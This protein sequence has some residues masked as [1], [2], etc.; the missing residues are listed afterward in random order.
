MKKLILLFL[1]IPLVSLG[2]NEDVKKNE[3]ETDL[4]LDGVVIYGLKQKIK[5]I[6]GKK[7][8]ILIY[9]KTNYKSLIILF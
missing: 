2:Q 4:S 6:K 1:L 8:M 9:Q 5:K 7:L 3:K